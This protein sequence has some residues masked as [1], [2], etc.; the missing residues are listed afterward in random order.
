MRASETADDPARRDRQAARAQR[1]LRARQQPGPLA[2]RTLARPSW[3]ALDEHGDPILADGELRLV[4][5]R[6]VAPVPGREDPAYLAVLRDAHL[7]KGLW[8]PLHTDGR[9]TM[10]H[11]DDRDPQHDRRR[12]RPGPYPAPQHRTRPQPEDLELAR[13]AA[14]TVRDA[15]HV[16]VNLRDRLL[17]QLRADDARRQDSDR[18][19]FW[20]GI[21]A[22]NDTPPGQPGP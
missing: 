3:V 18:D 20:R 13:R 2:F 19:A 4:D 5:Q 16:D 12:A 15:Q 1:R 17:E 8:A 7:L 14:L 21:H 10:A 11:G 22:N 9:A 6:T